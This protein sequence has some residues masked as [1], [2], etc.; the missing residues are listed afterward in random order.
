MIIS[1]LLVSSNS[2]EFCKRYYPDFTYT[3]DITLLLKNTYFPACKFLPLQ[4]C[5]F[6][7]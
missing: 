1:V 4:G 3:K 7:G 6:V 5:Y 2:K